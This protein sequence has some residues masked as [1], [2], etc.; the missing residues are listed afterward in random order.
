MT[1]SRGKA[2]STL[3]ALPRGQRDKS[4]AA[5]VERAMRLPTEYKRKTWLDELWEEIERDNAGDVGDSGD[6]AL[7]LRPVSDAERPDDGLPA[8]RLEGA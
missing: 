2:E 6:S 3:A 5:A 4:S 7:V 8:G 1:T